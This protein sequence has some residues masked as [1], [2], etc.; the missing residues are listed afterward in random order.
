M[1]G[2]GFFPNIQYQGISWFACF[3]G[4]DKGES[5]FNVLSWVNSDW[6]FIVACSNWRDGA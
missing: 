6:D 1:L 4:L 3:D 5:I 2:E